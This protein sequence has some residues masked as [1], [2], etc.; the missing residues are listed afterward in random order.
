MVTNLTAHW[1]VGL[2]ISYTLCFWAGWGAPGLW[3]GLTAG[4]VVAG[5]VL[6][7]VWWWRVRQYQRSGR[8]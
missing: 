3:W 4:L 8:L 5:V 2:P 7:T 1:L 6:T